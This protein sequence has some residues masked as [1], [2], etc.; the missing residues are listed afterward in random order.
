MVIIPKYSNSKWHFLLQSSYQGKSFYFFSEDLLHSVV[1][2]ISC[3]VQR[4]NIWN[5][6]CIMFCHSYFYGSVALFRGGLVC[7]YRAE[8]AHTHAHTHTSKATH[9]YV[10]EKKRQTDHACKWWK[11]NGTLTVREAHLKRTNCKNMCCFLCFWGELEEYKSKRGRCEEG[12]ASL[13]CV[14]NGAND[15]LNNRSTGVFTATAWPLLRTVQ[16]CSDGAWLA[17]LS[18][19]C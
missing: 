4:G 9:I 16:A 19:T 17:S 18:I 10:A 12:V 13:S 15:Q 11:S 1:F 14:L 2:I 8:D 5:L 6:E 3:Q 7:W